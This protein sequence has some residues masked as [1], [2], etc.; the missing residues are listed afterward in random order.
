MAEVAEQIFGLVPQIES[1]GESGQVVD[2][3]VDR[4]QAQTHSDDGGVGASGLTPSINLPVEFS[5]VG[6]AQ[7]HIVATEV[8]DRSAEITDTVTESPPGRNGVIDPAT[9]EDKSVREP[10]GP[11]KCILAGSTKPD[12][13]GPGRLWHE[14]SPVNSIETTREVDHRLSEQPPKKPYLLLFSSTP[15][16]EVLPERFVFDVIPADANTEA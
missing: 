16:T 10:G 8:F 9:E 13:D 5:Y 11:V 1:V 6:S 2:V 15:R 12:R 7:C 3:T 14:R 4:V